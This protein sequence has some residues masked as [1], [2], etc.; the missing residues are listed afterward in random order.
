M[1]ATGLGSAESAMRAVRIGV[2]A[3][4]AGDRIAPA[5]DLVERASLDYIVFECLAERTIALAQQARTNNPDLGYDPMLPARMRRVLPACRRAGTRLI[6]NMG[7]ANPIAAARRTRDIAQE[8]G[9]AGLRIAAIEGDDVLAL[10]ES[11]ELARAELIETGQ[12]VS[13]LR[14]R[15]V[16]ANAYIGCE[17]VVEALRQHA[18]VVLGGRIADPSLF[19]GAMIHHFD[20]RTDDWPKL[21]AGIMIGHLLECAGQLTGGYFADPPFKEVPDLAHLGFPYAEVGPDG[22][23]EFSKL[24][25]TGGALTLQ[26]AKE[27]LLY[28]IHDPRRYLTPDVAA[29]FSS[30]HLR[31]S[32]V[33]R[34]SASGASGSQRPDS[35]KVSI[36]YSDGFIGEGQITYAGTGA[37]DRARLAIAVVRQQL[38]ELGGEITE[39][40]MEMIG[41]NSVNPANQSANSSEVRVRIAGRTESMEQAELIGAAVEALYTNGPA[42][43]GGVTRSARPVIAIASALIPRDLVRTRIHFEV[44]S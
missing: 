9:L 25:H 10:F 36:G 21:G 15:I 19:L 39:L 40:R 37:A 11:G 44:T 18:D 41:V 5:L 12:P 1:R 4:Y 2:G 6:S 33:D 20:W 29:D 42:A 16:P 23:A 22:S 14:G 28:E 35:L 31:Q 7:A 32:G 30:V 8:L 13:T 3:G 38:E 43:G 24:L 26:T 27:Q 17:P 34:V